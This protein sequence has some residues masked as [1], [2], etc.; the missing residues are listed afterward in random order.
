MDRPVDAPGTYD[1]HLWAIVLGFCRGDTALAPLVHGLGA[2]SL[3]S[4]A[5][6]RPRRR[7]PTAVILAG[8]ASG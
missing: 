4:R 1:A 7:R 8:P 2:H 6:S 3:K 5:A